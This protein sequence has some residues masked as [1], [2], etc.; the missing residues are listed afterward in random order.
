MNQHKYLPFDLIEEVFSHIPQSDVATISACSQ[1]SK[2]F[3]VEMQKRLFEFVKLDLSLIC[4][5]GASTDPG[6]VRFTLG[7]I[8]GDNRAQ[9]LLWALTTNP[10]L[11]S[12]VHIFRMTPTLRPPSAPDLAL[13]P[14][15]PTILDILPLLSKVKFFFFNA[16]LHASLP[17]YSLFSPRLRTAIRELLLR[18]RNSLLSVSITAA[19]IFPPKVLTHLP[20]LKSLSI[21]S[22]SKQR[23][24]VT[25][26]LTRPPRQIRPEYLRIQSFCLHDYQTLSNLVELLQADVSNGTS[27]LVSFSHLATLRLESP[28]AS[29]ETIKSLINATY[30][31]ILSELSITAPHEAI[32]R[33]NMHP[34]THLNV[35]YQEAPDFDLSRLSNLTNLVISGDLVGVPVQS[36]DHA[37][38][39]VHSHC[40]WI[41]AILST[42]SCPSPN[43]VSRLSLKVQ[44]HLFRV[45]TVE[46]IPELPLAPVIDV[47]TEKRRNG[48]INAACVEFMVVELD[49]NDE[50]ADIGSDH[51]QWKTEV[52]KL[53]KQH[54]AVR[55]SESFIEFKTVFM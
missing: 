12:Y 27:A 1:T 18:N 9:Q 49:D 13:F 17:D 40:S 24:P 21:I 37:S 22:L 31:E 44:L 23:V 42:L 53:L 47:I 28:D 4:Y 51:E 15:K 55:S 33:Y 39:I 45:F 32:T 11:A 52:N 50:K 7:D 2:S 6:P 36:P 16:K 3:R 14:H 35:E 20:K 8:S 30:P 10:D 46:D 5:K 48:A 34:W 38:T 19:R 29:R 54:E 26:P 25:E 43:T 41:G